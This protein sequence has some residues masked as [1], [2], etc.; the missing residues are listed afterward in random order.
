MELLQLFPGLLR[1]V[2]E[3]LGPLG[4]PLTTVLVILGLLAAYAYLWSVIW[5]KAVEPI[6]ND[7]DRFTDIGNIPWVLVGQLVLV[8]MVISVA[9]LL[10]VMAFVMLFDYSRRRWILHRHGVT[11]REFQS[12]VDAAIKD[13]ALREQ[14]TD[15]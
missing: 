12:A 14:E 11:P 7:I 1:A 10:I 15:G 9:G 2:E 5:D 8:M 13:L 3:R 6:K 4:K